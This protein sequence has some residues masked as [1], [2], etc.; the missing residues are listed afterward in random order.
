MNVFSAS[1]CFFLPSVGAQKTLGK[2]FAERP[3][4][5]TR[6]RNVCRLCVR[7]VPFAECNTRQ[8]LYRVF[9]GLRRVPWAHG[10]LPH[11]G[12]AHCHSLNT[13]PN[14]IWEFISWSAHREIGDSKSSRNELIRKRA[15]DC[16]HDQSRQNQLSTHHT[17]A[18][19]VYSL[20]TFLH[21]T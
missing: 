16:P 11:S 12:S 20:S 3:I 17:C 15:K 19:H 13:E 2:V 7:R 10:K 4:K 9:F 1:H 21:I 5:N 14:S 18:C 8:R 6:Q